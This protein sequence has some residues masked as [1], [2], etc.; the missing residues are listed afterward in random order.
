M[1]KILEKILNRRLQFFLESNRLL[2]PQ[3]SGFRRNRSAIDNIINLEL[4]VHK[5]FATKRKVL[6]V[7]FDISRAYDSAWRYNILKKLRA[8]EIDGNFL[9]FVSNF[10]S[11]RTFRVRANNTLSEE[12]VQQNGTP[13]GSSLSVTLFLTAINDISKEIEAPIKVGLYADDLLLYISSN[14][15]T[16]ATKLLQNSITKLEEW[17]RQTG[18][19]FSSTK[20]KC[21]LFDKRPPSTYPVLE[22]HSGQLEFV[23]EFKFLGLVFDEKLKWEAHIRQLK[24]H[25]QNGLNLLKTL[26]SQTWGADSTTLLRIY[27]ALIRSKIDYG[28][29]S[30]STAKKSVLKKLDTIHNT[31]LRLAMG[32]YRTSPVESLYTEA[33]EPPLEIRRHFLSLTYAAKLSSTKYNPTY[34]HIFSNPGTV[35]QN[36]NTTDPLNVRMKMQDFNYTNI[37]SSEEENPPPW[38]VE[39]PLC[40]TYL[41]LF[42]KSSTPI[43]KLRKKFQ[44]IETKYSGFNALYTDASKTSDGERVGASVIT[45]MNILNFSMPPECSIYTGELYAIAEAIKLSSSYNAKDTVIFTDSLSSIQGIK[46]LYPKHPTL[47]NIKRQLYELRIEGKNIELV[48]IPSHIGIQGNE[49]ADIA[50]KN[51]SVD[52]ASR[53]L[54]KIPYTDMKHTIHDYTRNLWRERWREVQNKKLYEINPNLNPIQYSG[55]SRKHQVILTRLR[56]GHTKIT[57]QHLIQRDEAEVCDTCHTTLN[58]KHILLECISYQQQRDDA[59][60]SSEL[61]TILSPQNINNL[62]TFLKSINIFCKI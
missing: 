52:P 13:Q 19:T 59:S 53:I 15:V 39:I 12:K 16:S 45:G 27:R 8:W 47:K 51:A 35:H 57:H 31:A 3:Q 6:A 41:T 22:L 61:R 40:N 55:L 25:C 14:N 9:A 56:I 23:K 33:N 43:P 28:S 46:Q 54:Q 24:Q 18:F 1:C 36:N 26:S 34:E 10:L 49:R 62:V 11:N 30:Y 20:T 60:L 48:W 21:M 42:P 58:V 32:A 17:S 7:F 5:A 38:L 4:T 2:I 50:A 37:L 44:K 29:I